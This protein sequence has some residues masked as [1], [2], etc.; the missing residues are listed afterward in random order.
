MAAAKRKGKKTPAEGTPDHFE[1]MLE[2]PCQ[3]HAFPVK[4]LYKDCSLMKRFLPGGSKKRDQMKKSNPA[5]NDAKEKDNG[6]SETIGCLM[7][8]DGMVAYDSK[9]RQKLARRE[10][11][12][13]K[14]ATPTF[15]RWSGSTIT[16]DRSDHPESIP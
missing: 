11:Y 6:F 1:K 2:G 7:I 16:F 5:A 14:L 10:V 13:A 4:H 8:F 3:N 15:L 9:H 12:A